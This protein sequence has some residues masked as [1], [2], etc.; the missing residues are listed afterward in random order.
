MARFII[1]G[2]PDSEF[3]TKELGSSFVL[4]PAALVAEICINIQCGNVPSRERTFYFKPFVGS[5]PVIPPF[6]TVQGYLGARAASPKAN[7]SG[8]HVIFFYLLASWST[9][10]TAS[11]EFFHVK[12]NIICPTHRKEIAGMR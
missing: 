11:H 5:N 8:A 9:P 7:L 2:E 4:L 10:G 12:D 6:A 1:S 3:N